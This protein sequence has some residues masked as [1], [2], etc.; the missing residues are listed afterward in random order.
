MLVSTGNGGYTY[1]DMRTLVCGIV[2]AC[3]CVSAPA[4]AAELSASV[5]RNVVSLDDRLVLSVEVSGAGQGSAPELPPLDGFAVAHTERSTQIQI[6]N[7][8]M[9]TSAR[10]EYTLV[11]LRAGRLVI[12]PVTLREGDREQRTPP[13]TVEVLDRGRPVPPSPPRAAAG[14]AASPA[15]GA[16]PSSPGAAPPERM[17]IEIEAD[18]TNPWLREQ[19]IL[20]FR[21]CYADV[22]LADQPVYEAPPA[23]GFVEKHL[24]DGRSVNYTRV[25]NGRRYQVS[26]LKTALYPYRTGELA[27][28]PA[29]LKGNVL[30][31]PPR[32]ARARGFFDMD[33]FFSDPFFGGFAKKPFSLVSN[34]LRIDVQIGRAS[35]R[36]RV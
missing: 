21:F 28:G 4:G 8:Q 22:A 20:T 32:R 15:S 14:R 29:R 11:P 33:D 23:N 19:V 5:D 3:I 2:A 30:V 10:Y 26:E 7:F 35:C 13:I 9:M 1:A 36:E 6:A 12:G 17:F 31:D 18:K 24:G 16:P 34:E 27:V 25:L